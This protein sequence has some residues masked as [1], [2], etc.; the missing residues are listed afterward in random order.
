MFNEEENIENEA[1]KLFG[2]KGRNSF[3]V[4]KNYFEELE[5]KV[6]IDNTLLG[7]AKN[8]FKAPEGY[9]NELPSRIEKEIQPKGKIITM[10][11]PKYF[12]YAASV[13][14][15]VALSW[16]ALN[17][18]TKTN[19]TESLLASTIAYEETEIEAFFEAMT[20]TELGLEDI[21]FE[22]VNIKEVNT[23]D[24]LIIDEEI[25]LDPTDLFELDEE[26]DSFEY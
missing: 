2:L 13:A 9:F 4:P 16:F 3:K 8:T 1:P 5:Q 17:T 7:E 11:S 22:E 26:F 20:E 12:G 6:T 10:F 23:D 14:V 21:S 15:I 25:E 24:F 18:T 19:T